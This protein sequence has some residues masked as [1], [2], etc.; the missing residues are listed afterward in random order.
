[1]PI[2]GV[3]IS[4]SGETSKNI[5]ECLKKNLPYIFRVKPWMSSRDI[6]AGLP[7]H[8]ELLNQLKITDVGIFVITSE[9]IDSPWMQFEAGAMCKNFDHSR[10]IPYL[11]GL[12]PN[13]LRGPFAQIQAIVANKEGT[14]RLVEEVRKHCVPDELV[15]SVRE[16][17]K[18]F[19][20]R[21]SI[22][23]E[24]TEG[25]LVIF[26][27]D[28]VPTAAEYQSKIDRLEERVSSLT[29]LVKD[30][31]QS[32]KPDKAK[33][34]LSEDDV[35]LRAKVFEGGWRNP[36]SGS[37]GYARI[38]NGE[39]HMP[40]C[41][42]G[43]EK[44]TAAY[45]DWTPAGSRWFTRF[46]WLDSDIQGFAF[47]EPIGDTKIE[48]KWWLKDGDD[49]YHTSVSDVIKR[50]AFNQGVPSFW[51]RIPNEIIPLWAEEYFTKI[52]TEA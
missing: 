45:T 34:V 51:E 35:V 47:Y 37:H 20:P 7:W 12:E 22:Q 4:W 43:N 41:Y 10:I 17:F 1:M 5:A 31:V 2:P 33:E 36:K 27:G 46:R 30:V 6:P 13:Q 24:T 15:D 26:Q 8:L 48:G 9:N 28:S 21:I 32:W 49:Y 18:A 11:V 3:F 16:R 42:R 14:E 25:E 29:E 40:Y 38:V 39:L 23:L 52:E 19:W 50:G 44:L